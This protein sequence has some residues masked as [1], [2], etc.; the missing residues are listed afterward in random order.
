M[1]GNPMN[2]YWYFL[3]FIVM[4]NSVQVLCME[5]PSGNQKILDAIVLINGASVENREALSKN[6]TVTVS[7]NYLLFETVSKGSAEGAHHAL[8][9]GANPNVMCI[10]GNHRV[11]VLDIAITHKNI[12]ESE[13]MVALLLAYGA[14]PSPELLNFLAKLGGV[15]KR[16]NSLQMILNTLKQKKLV[17]PKAIEYCEKL[18]GSRG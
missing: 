9:A 5:Q 6:S 18:T 1:K 16:R 10:N 12:K 14:I 3:F 2:S 8:L 4:V 13:K 15:E 11:S 7:P 17:S